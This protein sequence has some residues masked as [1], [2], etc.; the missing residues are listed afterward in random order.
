MHWRDQARAPT[1]FAATVAKLGSFGA[2]L[3]AWI[4]RDSELG[5]P[6]DRV[7][8]GKQFGHR[9]SELVYSTCGTAANKALQYETTDGTKKE[10]FL[11]YERP[12]PPPERLLPNSGSLAVKLRM[13]PNKSWLAQPWH[14]I[15]GREPFADI[16]VGAGPGLAGGAFMDL[17]LNVEPSDDL[18]AVHARVRSAYGMM[19]T[20]SNGFIRGGKKLPT[21]VAMSALQ[22][23][24]GSP[25]P[26]KAGEVIFTVVQQPAEKWA[27]KLTPPEVGDPPVQVMI[28][29]Y[30]QPMYAGS[31]PT[32]PLVGIPLLLEAGRAATHNELHE[33]VWA[34][35]R[36][37]VTPEVQAEG[38]AGRRP[39]AVKV[40][41]SYG[42][43]PSLQYG[44]KVIKYDAKATCRELPQDDETVLGVLFGK[45]NACALRVD[46]ASQAQLHA[47][48]SEVGRAAANAVHAA[49]AAAAA[50][51]AA[52]AGIG[53]LCPPMP[54]RA[55]S[56]A[57]FSSLVRGRFTEGR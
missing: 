22:A 38:D 49:H 6:A 16:R 17:D 8:I 50:A 9:I 34:S 25:D 37:L 51:A 23:D 5:V 57:A 3:A 11:C 41:T 7:L 32:Y 1:L 45:T 20:D 40:C 31:P 48:V 55:V 24:D 46:W 33:Q 30:K 28:G 36:R 2:D 12:A 39:Y 43:T 53:W 13:T 44:D 47:D 52:A 27:K 35:V 26:L 29:A 56:H 14:Q 21:G 4:A 15:E 19:A 54:C 10:P 42:T 18:A